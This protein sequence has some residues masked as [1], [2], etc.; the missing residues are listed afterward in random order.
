MD[1]FFASVEQLDQ[2]ELRGKPVLVGG[3]P[4]KRG[5]VA[6]ASYEVG[7]SVEGT[8]MPAMLETDG[9]LAEER[10]ALAAVGHFGAHELGLHTKVCG[11]G[12]T[13][14]RPKAFDPFPFGRQTWLVL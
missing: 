9:S 13:G 2:P 12:V 14:R 5:G 1:A 6:A 3:R 8:I 11:S 4:E 7:N 10:R